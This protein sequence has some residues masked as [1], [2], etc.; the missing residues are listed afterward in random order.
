M[1]DVSELNQLMLGKDLHLVDQRL[2]EH[3]FLFKLSL[4]VINVFALD[5]NIAIILSEKFLGRD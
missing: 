2:K 5:R 4:V 1:N 3:N